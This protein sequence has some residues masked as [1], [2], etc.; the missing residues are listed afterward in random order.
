MILESFKIIFPNS[1]IWSNQFPSPNATLI[2][3]SFYILRVINPYILIQSQ[4]IL[5]NPKAL[6]E[7]EDVTS[8]KLY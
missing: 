5:I 6:N 4:S 7:F 3:S 1:Y 8:H 2:Y